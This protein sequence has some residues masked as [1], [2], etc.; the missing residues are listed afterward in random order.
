MKAKLQS[1]ASSAQCGKTRSRLL[2]SIGIKCAAILKVKWYFD[3]KR[4]KGNVLSSHAHL[5]N[6]IM[7]TI[8]MVLTYKIGPCKLSNNSEDKPL[9]YVDF[10]LVS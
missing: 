6:Q 9:V 10:L 3:V 7:H 2:F 4:A 5:F 8:L 1:T